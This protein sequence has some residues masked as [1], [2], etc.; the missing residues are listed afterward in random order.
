M[1]CQARAG[2]YDSTLGKHK[3]QLCV[4]LLTQPAHPLLGF[5]F[6]PM[7]VTADLVFCVRCKGRAGLESF[8]DARL[9]TLGFSIAVWPRV[10][11]DTFGHK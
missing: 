1:L 4:F 6:P 5:F 11:Q 7:A 3:G 9:V 2:P 10:D 8:P